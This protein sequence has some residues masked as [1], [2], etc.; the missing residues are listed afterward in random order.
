MTAEQAA[1]AAN[2]LACPSTAPAGTSPIAKG[3]GP[4]RGGQPVIFTFNIV[5]ATGNA[6]EV[7]GQ[8]NAWACSHE[9]PRQGRPR[10]TGACAWC[11]PEGRPTSRMLASSSA[12]SIDARAGRGTVTREC[13]WDERWN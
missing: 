8:G 9:N 10:R 7:G 12:A 5:N 11:E 3:E 2:P 4:E 6:F 1:H 13:G